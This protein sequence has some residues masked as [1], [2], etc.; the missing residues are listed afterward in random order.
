MRPFLTLHHPAAA[1]SYYESALWQNDTF[2]GLLQHNARNFGSRVALVDSRRELSWLDLR[3]WVDGIAADLKSFGLVRG[4]RVSSW[5]S[6]RAESVALFL[7]CSREGFAY[8]PSLHRSHTS[9][10]VGSFL[11]LLSPRALVTENG[12]GADRDKVNLDAVLSEISSLKVVYD[13]ETLPRPAPNLTPVHGDPDTIVYIA[14]TSGTTG[15]PKCVMHSDNTLLANARELV[16]DWHHNDSTVIFSLSPLSHHI[17]WVAVAQWLIASCRLV[18]NDP[19]AG[20]STLDWVID[21]GATY[22]MGVP[23][24]AIDLLAQQR[25]TGRKL[26]AVDI[27]YMAGAPIPPNVGEELMRQ[28]IRPQNVYGMTEN[29]SHQY[30]LPHDPVKTIVSTCGRG[31]QAYEIRIFDVNDSDR[32]VAVGEVGQIGGRGAALM[33]GYFGSQKAT[34]ASFNSDGWFMSGDLGSMDEHGNLRVVGRLK[35][36]IIR[37]GHNI[38]PSAIEAVTLRHPDVHQVAC[39]PVPD[40]RLG[41][42]V[43]L[44]VRGTVEWDALLGYLRE[45]GISR[46]DM[47]EYML[48]LDE[49][50]MTASGKI[51]KRRLVD[52]VVGQQVS[53]EP[54]ARPGPVAPTQ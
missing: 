21:S 6:N 23:T 4:D 53:I 19:P 7:A 29:S 11:R 41:E 35:D 37:G 24:H 40:S 8:N 51:L 15:E 9:A 20:R 12:W 14:F 30:T 13:V 52:M 28:G 44:A 50:P 49:F 18:V 48:R 45:S 22:L 34:E 42:R 32:R 1:R 33:L 17:A 10:E 3:D 43:C 25:A 47:P 38:Y 36:T 5:V 16:R 27:F 2:Y 54:V 26:G 31:G 46:F 39:I